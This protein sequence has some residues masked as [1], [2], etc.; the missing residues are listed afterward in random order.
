MWTKLEDHTY[1]R[2]VHITD[3]A[4]ENNVYLVYR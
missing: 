1:S 3:A 2:E 4:E